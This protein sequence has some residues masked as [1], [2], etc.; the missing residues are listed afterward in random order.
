MYT[1]IN[2]KTK[3]ALKEA[4]KEGQRV[5]VTNLTPWGEEPFTAGEC[6]VEGPHF[7]APHTWYARVMVREGRIVRVVS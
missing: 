7:P 2:F 4:L 1:V 3:K 5:E 6:S